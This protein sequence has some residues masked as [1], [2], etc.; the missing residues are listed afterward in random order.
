MRASYRLPRMPEPHLAAALG[1]PA[2]LLAALRVHH[3]RRLPDI[4]AALA[5]VEQTK[6]AVAAARQVD[7]AA[8]RQAHDEERPEDWSGYRQAKQD[9][10]TAQLH[11]DEMA[12][13][14]VSRPSPRFDSASTR[15]PTLGFG[16]STRTAA[17][18]R[19]ESSAFLD[20][21]A[22]VLT[23]MPSVAASSSGRRVHSTRWAVR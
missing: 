15:S 21:V 2:P 3:E 7:G 1:A 14:S 23:R 10:E 22:E 19:S 8:S 11:L 18:T 6:V 5:R 16:S 13:H 17:P 20:E 4:E 9:A 12:Y